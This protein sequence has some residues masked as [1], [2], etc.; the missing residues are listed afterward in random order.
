MRF[1]LVLFIASFFLTNCSQRGEE[2]V[3]VTCADEKAQK[4]SIDEIN[5]D[6]L[7]EIKDKPEKQLSEKIENHQRIVKK[8]GE[9]WDFC[10]CARVNDSINRVSQSPQSEKQLEK[11]MKRWNYVDVKCKEFITNPNRT[12]EERELHEK[13]VAKCLEGS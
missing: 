3:C 5:G 10:S 6:N 1:F 13:K 12:P 2:Q 7:L 9:Q 4:D 11:L 8:Y